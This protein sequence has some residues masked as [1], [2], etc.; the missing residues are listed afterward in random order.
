MQYSSNLI[1]GVL[2]RRYKRFLADVRLADGSVVTAHTANTGAMTGLAE[3]GFRVWLR[4]SGSE[5]RKYPLSWELVEADGTLVSINTGMAN[6][7]VREGLEQRIIGEFSEYGSIR[8][9]ASHGH[10]RLD[11]LLEGSGVRS[12]YLEVKSVTLAASG[13]ARFP[14]AVSIRGTKHLDELERV[15]AEGL[16]A[17][18]FFCVLR[19][20]VRE[21]GPADEIDPVFGKRLRQVMKAGVEVLAYSAAVSTLGVVLERP[22]PLTLR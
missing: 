7:I 6:A 16:R 10:C 13:I 20:D 12:C 11:F 17:V 18:V 21:V 3:P 8:A 22:L 14:D 2:I 4:D 1:E 19:N 9:E 5:S 15:A